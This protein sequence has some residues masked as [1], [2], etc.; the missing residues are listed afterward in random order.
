MLWCVMVCG[1]ESDVVL[2]VTGAGTTLSLRVLLT[3]THQSCQ[4]W[5]HTP[6]AYHAL[7][8]RS[9]PFSISF[10][11]FSFFSLNLLLLSPLLSSSLLLLVLAALSR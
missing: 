3:A 6:H 11:F 7:H 8:Y 1:A 2:G 5:H 4:T 10:T 9:S